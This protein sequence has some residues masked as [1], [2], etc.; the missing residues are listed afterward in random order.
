MKKSAL[1]LV[2][3]ENDFL[4]DKGIMYPAVKESLEANNVV[5][6]LN[7]VLDTELPPYW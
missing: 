7:K 2:D 6:H 1:I 3:C 5:A 4:S